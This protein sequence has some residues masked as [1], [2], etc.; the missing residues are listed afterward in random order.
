MKDFYFQYKGIIVK[1]QRG[2][3][4]KNIKRSASSETQKVESLL[5]YHIGQIVSCSIKVRKDIRRL[6]FWNAYENLS[7]LRRAFV[8]IACY[9]RYYK[10]KF[11]FIGRPER[12]IEKIWSQKE[13]CVL[14]ST[15]PG[16]D[17]ASLTSA[18]SLLLHETLKLKQVAINAGVTTILKMILNE[19]KQ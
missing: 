12:D 18:F 7:Q 16:N 3:L 4:S 5:A 13:L 19:I 2:K 10:E 6:L 9:E 17:I 1:D 8:F 11:P 15:N 14:A